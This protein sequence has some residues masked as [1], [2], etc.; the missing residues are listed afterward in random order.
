MNQNQREFESDTFDW[1]PTAIAVLTLYIPGGE[2][3]DAEL[4]V[5]ES[6][7]KAIGIFHKG[8]FITIH[9]DAH[10]DCLLPDAKN[11]STQ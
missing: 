8:E 11:T 7:R 6:G 10:P 1:L 5:D 9:L 3:A 2:F 4:P